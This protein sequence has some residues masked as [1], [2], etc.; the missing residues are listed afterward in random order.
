[1]KK[2][3]AI[4]LNW[5]I[6]AASAILAVLL[7]T[8]AKACPS[9]I[10]T[11]SG[12]KAHMSCHYTV[13]AGVILAVI[14]IIFAAESALRQSLLAL[15]GI[16]LGAAMLLLPSLLGICPMGMACHTS[17]LCMRI[18]GAVI[19]LIGIVQLLAKGEKDL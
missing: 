18:G 2:Q 4:K 15:T 16:V 12:G 1:M 8:V 17:A 7:L 13:T 5:L 10:D 3:T 19:A 14:I 9:M 11:A 6:A